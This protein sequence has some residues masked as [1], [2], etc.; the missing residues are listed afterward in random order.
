MIPGPGLTMDRL[1]RL[2]ALAMA[3]LT[4]A[5]LA[6]PAPRPAEER[7]RIVGGLAGIN[8]YTKHEEPFWTRQLPQLTGGRATAEIVPFD[9][10][11][12][13][14]EELLSVVKMGAVPFA[15]VLLSRSAV[16]E[17]ELAGID[18]AGLNPDI[19]AVK[20][21]VAAYRPRLA[22]LLRQRFGIELLAVYAYPAQVIFCARPM[23][24]LA[25]LKGRRVRVSSPSQAD[26]ISALGAEPVQTA[27]SQVVPSLRSGS[28]ECA[29]T[30]TM[31]GNTIG[32]HEVTTYIHPMAVSWGLAAFVANGASWA[33]LSEPLRQTLSLELPK[34]E[35]RIW[36][37][38]ERETIEGLACN[39]GAPACRTGTKGHMKPVARTETDERRRVEILQS[40]VLPAWMRRCGEACAVTWRQ[41]VGRAA[42]LD[43]H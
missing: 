39:T 2:A 32:L 24:S 22:E 1:R 34:L 15:T 17:P 21:T 6:Q 37:D 13:S 26:F 29:I 27:F 8:Q 19:E 25:D 40:S 11:G 20:R 38:S 30:G 43:L 33:A 23:S 12:L 36:A 9:R 4:S 31:S 41:T 7:L 3:C 35:Q 42:A 10:A 14:G 16:V 28:V 5:A 18:L